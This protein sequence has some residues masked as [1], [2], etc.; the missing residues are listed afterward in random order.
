[1]EILFEAVKI[2]VKNCFVNMDVY[3]IQVFLGVNDFYRD[4]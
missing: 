4:P 1:M 2:Y 3:L